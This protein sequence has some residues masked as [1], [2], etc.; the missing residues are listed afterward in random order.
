MCGFVRNAS[1]F[2]LNGL[3]GAT[4]PFVAKENFVTMLL[5]VV[6]LDLLD[7]SALLLAISGA[8]FSVIGAP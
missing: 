3:C 2:V 4:P 8:V 1:W 7:D 5:M 6:G